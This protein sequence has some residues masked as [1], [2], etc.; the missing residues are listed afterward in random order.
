MQRVTPP[1]GDSGSGSIP[2]IPEHD[3]QLGQYAGRR[4]LWIIR[5]ASITSGCTSRTQNVQRG[6]GLRTSHGRSTC[7][8]PDTPARPTACTRPQQDRHPGRRRRSLEGRR[9]RHARR[10][11]T[12]TVAAG[13]PRTCPAT[14]LHSAIAGRQPTAILPPPLWDMIPMGHADDLRA[15]AG[16]FQN[17]H[18]TLDSVATELHKVLES[19][20]SNNQCADLDTL[21]EFWDHIGPWRQPPNVCTGFTGDRR[22]TPVATHRMTIGP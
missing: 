3:R 11:A 15:V 19:M 21:N 9:Q 2:P 14:E 7:A 4:E 13:R 18:D 5:S 6:A 20:F 8:A 10:R 1:S 16:A 17:A 22:A 12:A